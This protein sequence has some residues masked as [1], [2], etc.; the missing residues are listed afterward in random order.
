MLKLLIRPQ[1]LKDLE[2]IFDYTFEHWSYDQ[3]IKYNSMIDG[4]LNDIS[5]GIINGKDYNHSATAYKI[6]KT[7]KHLIFYR[8]E[9]KICLIVRIL[10]EKMDIDNA[11]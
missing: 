8:F 1:A 4:C 2:D 5:C 11:L 10:H 3:A 6:V 9:N 7:G